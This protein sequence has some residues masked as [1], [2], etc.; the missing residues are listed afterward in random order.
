LSSSTEAVR[1]LQAASTIKI[2][3][4]VAKSIPARRCKDEAEYGDLRI[5]QRPRLIFESR[6]G[7]IWFIRWG[8]AWSVSN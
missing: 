2:S 4:V 8:G 1:V 3:T 6:R 5:D 7:R